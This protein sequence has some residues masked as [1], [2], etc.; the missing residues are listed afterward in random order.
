MKIQR[1][2]FSQIQE[3]LLPGKVLVLY[4]PRQ[5]GKTTLAQDLLNL[6]PLKSHFINADELFYREALASQDKQRLKELL[7]DTKLLII[8]EAQRVPNI[9]LNLKILVDNFPDVHIL[10]TGSASFDLANKISEP[11]TGRKI[12]FT[13]FPI[14]Y[15]EMQEN[16]GALEARKQLERW[17]IWGG[18]PE[19]ISAET[20]KLRARLLDELVGSYLYKDLLEMENIQH[21]EKIVDFIKTLNPTANHFQY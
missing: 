18:Y 17:L 21:A 4:G 3:Y 6:S 7:G 14:S 8:D 19:I 11:L 15:G 10:A 16:I 1:A 20:P 9:G 5:V 13:L 12:T 2:L